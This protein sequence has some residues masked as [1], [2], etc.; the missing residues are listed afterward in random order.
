MQKSRISLRFYC[1]QTL[2]ELRDLH[3]RSSWAGDDG[4]ELARGTYIVILAE[5][6]EPPNLGGALGAEALGVDGVGEAG[7][8][9]LALL[10]DRESEDGEIAADDAAADGLALALAGAAGSVAGVALGEEEADTGGGNDSLLHREALLVVAT[11]DSEDVTLPLIAERVARHLSAHLRESAS[12]EN[13]SDSVLNVRASCDR[14]VSHGHLNESA[15]V[16]Y[17]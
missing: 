7:N 16:T 6:E 10:D 15:L 8:V 9:L 3:R 14:L 5:A 1:T 11:G 13:E 2:P 4:F 17:S 12:A